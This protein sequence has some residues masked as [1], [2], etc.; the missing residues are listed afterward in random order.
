MTFLEGT[1]AD[2]VAD[3]VGRKRG[4]RVGV[5]IP[6]RNE[7]ATIADVVDVAARLRDAGL[8]DDVVVV[9]DGSADDT[10]LEAAAAGARVVASPNGPGKGQALT[11][12]LAAIDTEL[13]VFLDAD[14][15]NFSA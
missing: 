9:D 10:P 3:L 2:E 12:G 11:A 8:V 6:A 5:C 4:L 7:A 15:T 14:V 13:V 1:V